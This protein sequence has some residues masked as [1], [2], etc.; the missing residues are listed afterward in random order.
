MQE[1]GVRPEQNNTHGPAGVGV[2]EDMDM[3]R[4]EISAHVPA[5]V[6]VQENMDG[7]MHDSI[8]N[9]FVLVC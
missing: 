5:A 1:Q 4:K 6:H 8:S 3:H 9:S 2:Q 7:N